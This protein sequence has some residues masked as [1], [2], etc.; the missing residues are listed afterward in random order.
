MDLTLMEQMVSEQLTAKTIR[1]IPEKTQLIMGTIDETVHVVRRISTELRP[2][3]LDDL[4]LAAAI[5]WQ[6]KDFQRRSDVSCILSIP[7]EDVDVS[8]E[9]ATAVFR[10]THQC[11]APFE[12]RQGLGPMALEFHQSHSGSLSR[13]GCSACESAPRS[14]ADRSKLRGFPAKE[15]RSLCVCQFNELIHGRRGADADPA[16]L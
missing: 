1:S 15:R 4:G 9:Q 8:R 12:G 16:V 2:G 5:E 10:I 11:C 3:I 13:S 14:L 7:E 6:A